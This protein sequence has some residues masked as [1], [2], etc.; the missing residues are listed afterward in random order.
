MIGKPRCSSYLTLASQLPGFFLV[1]YLLESVLR[2]FKNRLLDT[3][4]GG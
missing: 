3:S 1:F 4:A 2:P